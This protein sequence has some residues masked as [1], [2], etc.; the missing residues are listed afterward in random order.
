FQSLNK[1]L[2]YYVRTGK[3]LNPRKGVYTKTEYD[4]EEL[5]CNIFTPSYLSLEYVLQKS[6][7][8]FQYDSRL[9]LVSY[10]TR[11]IE[12]AGETLQFRKVKGEILVNS[13]GV[14]QLEGH[15]SMATPERALLDVIYL[16]RDYYFDNLHPINRKLIYKL[17]P[18]Y[19]S[20]KLTERVK[21]LL[22]DD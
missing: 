7:I 1:K 11:S 6:G 2:N 21:S 15:I 22:K 18:V 8:V 4:P 13:A 17:L 9:T 14:N 10:L 19:Q 12:I 3:L 16:D 20:K 5:A